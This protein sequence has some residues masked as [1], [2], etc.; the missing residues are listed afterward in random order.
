MKVENILKPL[1]DNCKVG[2]CVHKKCKCGHCSQYH[3]SRVG[4]CC[5]INQ[6]LTTCGCNLFETKDD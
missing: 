4:L 3:I 5:Q 1:T 6:D 2:K